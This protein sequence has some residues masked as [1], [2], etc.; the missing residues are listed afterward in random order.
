[1][2]F[3]RLLV[4]AVL[5]SVPALANS[6]VSD[7]LSVGTTQSTQANPRA[8]SVS[9]AL[10]ATFELNDQF[11][12]GA[13]AVLTLEGKTPAASRGEF[14]TSGSAIAL[15]SLGL[16]WDPNDHVST[17]QLGTQLT[18]T[19]A[20]GAS[21][22]LNAR[23]VAQSANASLAFDVGYDTAG[24]SNLEWSFDAGLTGS[25]YTTTQ[26]ID[27]IRLKGAAYDP[28]QL[29]TY[30][31][32]HK[33]GQNACSPALLQVLKD[34]PATLDSLRT[35]LGVTSTIYTDTDVTL[36]GDFYS[37]SQDPSTVGIFSV[38]ESGKQ[39]ISG[40]TGVP[41]APLRYLIRPDVVHRFGDLSV[42]LWVQ[43]GEYVSGTAQTTSGIGAKV[44][45]KFTK[46]FRMW[47]T[48]GGQ[49]DVDSSG[50][51]SNSGNLGLGAGY[52]F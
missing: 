8:G 26:N 41:I 40:G 22:P 51:D 32:T 7:E 25:H 27:L 6:S 23:L 17:Q 19:D 3:A 48:A 45:Y 9:D 34:Q 1:M 39:N 36:G 46:T 21:T 37:Y 42:K 29:V 4:L 33:K 35:S 12:I 28:A 10:N 30:C 16:D 5:L 20:N 15:L 24:D 50:T 31:G 14:P 47:V 11:S 2:R 49:K 18:I 44:Q 43:A 38:G 13:G 52:R